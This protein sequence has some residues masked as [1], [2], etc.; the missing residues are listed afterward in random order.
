MLLESYGESY[1][2]HN[3]C[4]IGVKLRKKIILCK[5]DPISVCFRPSL[6]G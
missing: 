5:G 6:L 1:V 4:A 3:I 2:G